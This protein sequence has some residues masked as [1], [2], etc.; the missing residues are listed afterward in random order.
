V[1]EEQRRYWAYRKR[2]AEQSWGIIRHSLER[3]WTKIRD[4]VPGAERLEKQAVPSLRVR[5]GLADMDFTP[6]RLM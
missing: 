5:L 4:A 3:L 1:Q 6:V 2:I